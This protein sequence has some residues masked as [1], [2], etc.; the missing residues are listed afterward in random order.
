LSII[1]Y[2]DEFAN[3]TFLI[4]EILRKI[5]NWLNSNYTLFRPLQEK[6]N[7]NNNLENFAKLL[8]QIYRS[9]I[10]IKFL[11]RKFFTILE[12]FSIE[13]FQKCE[14]NLIAVVEQKTENKFFKRQVLYSYNIKLKDCKISEINRNFYLQVRE[15]LVWNIIDEFETNNNIYLA[16]VFLFLDQNN[17]IVTK[18]HLLELSIFR[19]FFC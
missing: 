7:Q 1:N 6:Y 16:A 2:R 12:N 5:K 9:K 10:I 8:Y 13:I 19:A 3:F 11:I 15:E 4:S 14:S 17:I 18:N